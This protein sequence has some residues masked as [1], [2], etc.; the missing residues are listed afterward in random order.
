MSVWIAI[1]QEVNAPTWS[2][3]SIHKAKSGAEKA[4]SDDLERAKRE[5]YYRDEIRLS[6]YVEEHEVRP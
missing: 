2:I 6:R 5:P 4:L 1:K 3:L